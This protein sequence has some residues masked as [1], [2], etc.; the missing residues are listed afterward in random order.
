MLLNY[1]KS[2]IKPYS[3]SIS[4]GQNSFHN[5]PSAKYLGVTWDI[6]LNW[7][8]HTKPIRKRAGKLLNILASITRLKWGAHP[9]TVLAVYKGLVRTGIEWAGFLFIRRIM[10]KFN[11]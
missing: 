3:K 9:E 6:R 8:I 1:S 4:I 7:Q 11:Y 5:V 10:I 2:P